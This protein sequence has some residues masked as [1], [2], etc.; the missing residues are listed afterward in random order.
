MVY[1][2]SARVCLLPPPPLPSPCAILRI[3]HTNPQQES[4]RRTPLPPPPPPLPLNAAACAHCLLGVSVLRERIKGARVCTYIY[5][6]T[7][8]HGWPKK[9]RARIRSRNSTNHAH[10]SL[11][12]AMLRH[13]LHSASCWLLYVC[14]T[15]RN[16]IVCL[17]FV[18]SILFAVKLAFSM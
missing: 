17:M 10:R 5:V 14:T 16:E 1:T 2:C 9:K 6:G 13:I 4:M 12:F 18:V 7:I 11:N 3:E 15:M 8:L